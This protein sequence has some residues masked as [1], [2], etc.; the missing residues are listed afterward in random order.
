MSKREDYRQK[1]SETT[2]WDEY[3]LG[4]SGLPGPRANLELIQAVA[5]VGDE[6]LFLRYLQWT[7]DRVDTNSPPV[8]LA[9]CGT[10]GLGRLLA[11]GKL[12]YFEV[13]RNLASDP[14]W[15]V[16]EGVA[17]ALQHFGLHAMDHLLAEMESW[18][19]GNPFEKRAV[20]AGLCEPV[21]LKNPVYAKQVVDRLQQITDGIKSIADRKSDGFIALRKALAYGWSVA[22]VAA[23]EYGF[24]RLQA[25]LTSPDKDLSW[26]A[27]ENMKKNRLKKIIE[28]KTI[29]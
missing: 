4:E 5:D 16:R 15:R 8:F 21:L 10:V 27:R 26:I 9:V 14:R 22:I 18:S 29:Q 2:H 11:E 25:M 7:P 28:W 19:G 3:L 1:L 24:P 6:A 12:Q 20:V 17:M 23:P 13:L